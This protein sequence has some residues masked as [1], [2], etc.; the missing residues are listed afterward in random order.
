MTTLVGATRSVV[1]RC[2]F[3]TALASIAF[4]GSMAAP[5]PAVPPPAAGGAVAAAAPISV[6]LRT[7]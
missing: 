7:P 4:I 1:R 5:A 6:P 2:Q 3:T